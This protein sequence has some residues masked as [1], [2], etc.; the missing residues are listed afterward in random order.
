MKTPPSFQ[1]TLAVALLAGA[2]GAF[3]AFAVLN[4]APA[5]APPVRA[6]SDGDPGTIAASFDDIDEALTRLDLRL[7]ALELANDVTTRAPIGEYVTRGELEDLVDDVIARMLGAQ[8]G[9]A[10]PDRPDTQRTLI[11]SGGEQGLSLVSYEDGASASSESTHADSDALRRQQRAEALESTAT[12]YATRYGLDAA[13]RESLLGALYDHEARLVELRRLAAEGAD[14]DFVSQV[15]GE[16]AQ[17]LLSALET[18][19]TPEQL[20]MLANSGDA[21]RVMFTSF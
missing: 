16:N 15:L 2:V 11:V 21:A 19:L 12:L 3:L 13:Q 7:T 20:S 1:Y 5:T 10:L 14:R 9:I 4:D 17:E 8:D 18:F 6:S